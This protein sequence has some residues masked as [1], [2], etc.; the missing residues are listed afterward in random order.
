VPWGLYGLSMTELCQVADGT[1]LVTLSS[2]HGMATPVRIDTIVLSRST[3]MRDPEG[4]RQLHR[5][6]ANARTCCTQH[7]AHRLLQSRATQRAPAAAERCC[8]FCS[9]GL[10]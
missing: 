10:R 9:R 7:G 5:L 6:A 1:A 8:A 4:A 3:L 2:A